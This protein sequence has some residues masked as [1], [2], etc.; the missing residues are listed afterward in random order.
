MAAPYA[1]MAKKLSS[2]F[3]CP[4]YQPISNNTN[5]AMTVEYFFKKGSFFSSNRCLSGMT[6][7]FSKAPAFSNSAMVVSP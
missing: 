7:I 5:D 3:K 4:A 6:L 2:P 1:K